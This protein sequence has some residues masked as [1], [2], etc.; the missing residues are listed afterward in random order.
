MS[1]FC[2]KVRRGG[3]R[4]FGVLPPPGPGDWT[5]TNPSDELAR[6]T[7]TPSLPPPA[8]TICLRYRET[9]TTTWTYLDSTNGSVITTPALPSGKTYDGQIAFGKLS[10]RLSEF[11]TTKTVFIPT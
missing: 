5:W 10:P 8:T 3:A 2:Q 7:Y 11:S 1:K 6:A 4:A 9:G